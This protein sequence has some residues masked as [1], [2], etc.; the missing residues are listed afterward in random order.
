KSFR[1]SA[2]SDLIR[3]GFE[4]A[5]ISGDAELRAGTIHLSCGISAGLRGTRKQYTINGQSVRYAKFLGSVKVVTFIPADLQLVSGGPSLRRAMLNGAL[6][7]DDHGYYRNLARYQKT[8]QQK[9]A[10]LRGAVGND[11]QLLAIYNDA[12][13]EAGSA[14]ILSRVGFISA[15][16][17]IASRVYSG[18]VGKESLEVCYRPNVAF[19]APTLDDVERAFAHRLQERAA[20]EAQR[21]ASLVG[22]HRDEMEFLLNGHP[23]SAF[24]SQGQQRTAVLALKVAE[25]T[26]MHERSNEAPL[27]LLDDVLSELDS[28]RA[29]AFLAGVSGYEQAFITATHLP[30]ALS[31][32]RVHEVCAAELRLVA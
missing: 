13:I 6:S 3:E 12:L 15:I 24:G 11:P 22:P 32:A 29:E 27:L 8:L 20:A 30:H 14:L 16:N 7:Q 19:E 23:L 28:A 1:T 5:S 9:S 21:A 10:M 2:E 25:Y 26:V 18:W 17:T 4:L 31:G